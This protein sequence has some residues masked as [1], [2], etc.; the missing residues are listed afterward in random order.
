[1]IRVIIK[2]SSHYLVCQAAGV[3]LFKS[4]MKY[5]QPD[6]SKSKDTS[7]E[8]YFGKSESHLLENY[9]NKTLKEAGMYCTRVLKVQLI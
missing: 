1:M 6:L 4:C 2:S 3:L 9:L 8:N 5:S 7:L